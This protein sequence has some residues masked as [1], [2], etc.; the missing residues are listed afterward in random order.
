M[1]HLD[2]GLFTSEIHDKYEVQRLV[3]EY[4]NFDIDLVSYLEKNQIKR[5][6]ADLIYTK[7][8]TF[9]SKKSTYS[10]P[11]TKDDDTFN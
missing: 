6:F 7:V 5:V 9:Q 10:T 3:D 8:D 2:C 1:K 11:K 4:V